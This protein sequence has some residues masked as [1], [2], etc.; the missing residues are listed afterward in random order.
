MMNAFVSGSI[1]EVR[2][3]ATNLLNAADVVAVDLNGGPKTEVMYKD[4]KIVVSYPMD[5]K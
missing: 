5:K 1:D 4:G 2:T 3:L